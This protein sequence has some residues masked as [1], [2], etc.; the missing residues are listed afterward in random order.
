MSHWI[1]EKTLAGLRSAEAR[2]YRSPLPTRVVS[3]GEHL[4][5]PQTAE[6]RQVEVRMQAIAERG[7]ARHGM[8]RRA[9][10]AS[11]AGI[12]AGLL[13]M[14]EVYGALFQVARSEAE[15]P[16]AAQASRRALEHQLVFDVQLHFV[17]DRY[18]FEGLLGLREIAKAWNPRLKG[19]KPSFDH[20][21]FDN[22]VKEVF[23]DSQTD[24][25][26]LSGAPSENLDNWFLSNRQL[27]EARAVVNA[28]AGSRRL[29]CHS[30]FTPGWPGW[31]EELDRAIEE[32][33]PDSWKGYTIGDPLQASKWPWRLDDEKLVYPAYERMRKAGITTVCIH[34]GLLPENYAE[35]FPDQWQYA[36]VDDVG[37]AARDW[38]DLTFVIYHS[39]L[40]PFG[41]LPQAHL[42]HFEQTGRIDWVTDLAEI[43]EKYGVSNVY[44]E[45]GSTFASSAVVHP[46]HCAALLGTL[47]RGMGSDRV[48]WGT[49]SVWYGSPQ[50]QIEAFR[51]IEIPEDMQKAYGFAPLGAADGPVR[52]AVLGLNAA[53]LY[54]LEL[55]QAGK[56]ADLRSDYF[57]RL[58]REY[59]D[60]GP[61]PSN[62]AYGF[63]APG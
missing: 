12:A 19:E 2:A 55:D 44:A 7:A 27:A 15:D 61:R 29:L 32:L 4:P 45:L 38:P 3:N 21:K 58:R 5:P 6:Q 28:V 16:A 20:Y 34:K 26:L 41:S 14:N 54:G 9:F 22:F 8:D 57:A 11:A 51:R 42:E 62:R 37:Q 23:L 59:E 48:L 52:N 39:G 46:R 43:P 40:K 33:R 53:R 10:L 25:G 17:H 1:D 56:P 49:D 47:I 24:I 13:A 63:V 60:A 50:W 36:K 35:A 30:V 18:A 31:L